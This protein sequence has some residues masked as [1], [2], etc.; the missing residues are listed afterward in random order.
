M[1]HSEDRDPT[2]QRDGQCG[3]LLVFPGHRVHDSRL[4]TQLAA[5]YAGRRSMLTGGLVQAAE[6]S[7]RASAAPVVGPQGQDGRR[8]ASADGQ[9]NQG[10]A[11]DP[12]VYQI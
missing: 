10:T 8:S 4:S 7:R 5:G 6:G 3:S 9:V 11:A 1:V 12:F 2:D